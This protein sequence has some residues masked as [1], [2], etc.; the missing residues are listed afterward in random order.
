MKAV[1]FSLFLLAAGSHADV[2]KPINTLEPSNGTLKINDVLFNYSVEDRGWFTT[3]NQSK[4]EAQKSFLLRFE[5]AESVKS[6]VETGAQLGVT[7]SKT[8]EE[9]GNI[10][11]QGQVKDVPTGM[12]PSLK[13]EIVNPHVD[14]ALG[15]IDLYGVF[16]C[17][18]TVSATK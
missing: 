10:E 13:T 14:N 15:A 17:L 9:L 16:V 6:L 1:L 18:V 5:A 8:C 2:V 11:Y 4:I 12:I 3:A 7:A